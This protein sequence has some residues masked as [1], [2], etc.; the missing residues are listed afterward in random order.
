M[1]QPLVCT[2][3]QHQ[4]LKGSILTRR[5]N[6]TGASIQLLQ[7]CRIRTAGLLKYAPVLFVTPMMKLLTYTTFVC[8]TDDEAVEIYTSFVYQTDDKAI[9]VYTSFVHNNNHNRFFYGA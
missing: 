5:E 1:R 4:V 8:H 7:P 3:K 6:K 2:D 9:D